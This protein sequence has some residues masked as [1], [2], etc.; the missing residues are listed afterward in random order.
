MMPHAPNRWRDRV[1]FGGSKR[2][3]LLPLVAEATRTEK[4]KYMTI[5]EELEE[6]IRLHDA[7]AA[8]RYN[9]HN[10][11][12]LINQFHKWHGKA[13]TLFSRYI[14][15]NDPELQKFKNIQEGNSYVLAS[16]FDEIETAFCILID[17]L[18][19]S[20]PVKLEDFIAQGESIAATIKYVNSPDG[21]IRMF[22]VY[23]IGKESDYQTWKNKCIRLLELHFKND[24]SLDL[25][26]EAEAKFA[27]SHNTPKYLQDMIGVLKACVE[28]PAID[29]DKISDVSAATSPVTINVM[30]TQTQSQNV[31]IEIFLESI[32]DEIPGKQYKELKAIAAKEKDP[33]KAKSKILEKVKSFGEDVLSN[34]VANIITNPTIWGGLS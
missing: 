4:I 1:L 12:G 18:R 26:K 11:V 32:K 29:E 9:E 25:F 23:S 31:A 28:M 19:N 13:S 15:V 8:V 30:Q 22:D 3:P 24:G 7:Y 10:P 16:C 14:S 27:E 21:V 20:V 2:P 17:K 6:I 34:I 33:V 5:K